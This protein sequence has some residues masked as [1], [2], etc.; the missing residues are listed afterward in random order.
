MLGSPL[1]STTQDHTT[2]SDGHSEDEA[3]AQP[4]LSPLPASA[5]SKPPD[6]DPLSPP[7]EEAT[8]SDDEFLTVAET[9]PSK[10]PVEKVHE[11]T[12]F[13]GKS[14]VFV[15]TSQVFNERRKGAGVRDMPDRRKEF[16]ITPDVS[17]VTVSEHSFHRQTIFSGCLPY[18]S[19]LPCSLST[20]IWTLCDTSRTVTSIIS[21]LSFR[22][23][24]APLSCARWRMD[25]TRSTM[26]LA[27]LYY[28]SVQSGADTPKIPG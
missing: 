11:N 4:K 2:G 24:T 23:S 25:C 7:E 9:D 19:P 6:V 1:S 12:R 3:E 28:W 10:V 21:T 20:L 17:P 22:F 18:S 16:W 8:Y 26:T 14:S 13:Y 5:Y 27:L 15:L